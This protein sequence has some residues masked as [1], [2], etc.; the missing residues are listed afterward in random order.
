ML[1]SQ[2]MF[3]ASAIWSIFLLSEQLPE[4]Y[5][6]VGTIE[7][8]PISWAVDVS[9]IRPWWSHWL[10]GELSDHELSLR[11]DAIAAQFNLINKG[12]SQGFKTIFK[13]ELP[14]SN[15]YPND[16]SELRLKRDEQEAV[17][18]NIDV[19]LVS[20]SSVNWATRQHPLKRTKRSFNDPKFN[21]QW[22]LVC[23]LSVVYSGSS[24]MSISLLI[25]LGE[26]S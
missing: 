23:E 2:L 7:R 25:S 13:F 9:L 21:A 16:P 8:E 10:M 17:V 6:G 22:H 1:R 24:Q 18:E 4:L 15:L 26:Q 19:G 20:H 3:L 12:P 14:M 5:D 11:A